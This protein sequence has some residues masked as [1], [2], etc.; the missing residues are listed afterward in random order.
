ME[1]SDLLQP[2]AGTPQTTTALVV[3]LLPLL[4][5]LVLFLAGK[6]LP[7]K[8]D[9]FGISITAL[10]F[11]LSV[12][13]FTETWNTA[14]Y[15]SRVTWF[16]LP[17]LTGTVTNFTAGILLD[18]LTVLMLVIV[19]F[20][21][22]LVQLFSVGYMH[23]DEGYSRYFAYLGLFTFSM[24]GIVLVDNLLLLFMFWE[25]VGFSS[26]LLIGFWYEKP[27]AVAAN[28]KAFLVNRVGDIGLLLGLF[29]FYTYFRTFDLEALRA[30]ISMGS[31]TS[32][33][34]VVSYLFN[35]QPW[36]VAL[37]PLLLTL[38]G[39]GLF[40][41]CVGKSA[42]FPLQV[43]LPDA[44]QGPTPVSSLIHAA[45]MV[46]AG[47]YLLARCYAFFTV[48]A[49]TIIAIIGAVTALLG[50]LAALTQYDVKAV[51]AFSTISQLGYMVMGMGVG[52]YDASL[53]HLTTHAFFKAAL[54]LN[55]G[56]IIH[57]MHRGLHHTHQ[58]EHIDAQDIRYMGGLRKALPLT[59]YTYLVAAAA[60]IGLP[61]FSGF[62]SKD[63]I[64]SGSWAWAQTMSA[65][66]SSLYFIVPIL[67]FTV[68]LLTAFYMARHMWFI[69]FGS[70]RLPFDVKA[71]RL[72]AGK[73]LET[74]MA[75]PVVVLGI[76][77]LG[78]F[79]SLNPLSFGDSWLMDG[80]NLETGNAYAVF[81]ASGLLQAIALQ[82]ETNHTVHLVIGVT[83]AVLG[84][85]GIALAVSKYRKK[86]SEALLQEQAD[87]R[88]EKFSYHHFYLDEVSQS[89]FVMPALALARGLYRVDKRVI[90]YTLNNG[91]KALVVFS[92]V[93][94]WFDRWAVDGVVWLLGALSKL[95]GSFGRLLQNGKVQS[96]YAYSLFGFILIILYI[97]LF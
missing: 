21:S 50:A 9:W 56:I 73:E 61:F 44:M 37:S 2:L 25:L 55:A 22:M 14:T 97:V 52:A 7:R 70:F 64:L 66:G 19:T 74:V 3:L 80:I 86:S 8:G 13:L 46:A 76:L 32:G 11:A 23:G 18:N 83:S 94:A 1:L 88:L 45:T 69:F 35:G 5:F 93:V 41:G 75:L 95:L 51:L 31:W 33:D 36:L 60:L 12:W 72:K 17:T 84:V 26:Y 53:F 87:S 47:V 89:F 49:L 48:D 68:V 65:T 79:F 54:F 91:S 15:H 81:L 27:A 16:S 57:A 62:L 29:T 40:M 42:Q 10:A 96:Y 24:L 82:D 92:K 6:H 71:L 38:A 4:G 58:P 63:A 30:L 77:S 67:G 78:V 43:W 20:I 34:F 90:D 39:L 28:K 59:F 85:A